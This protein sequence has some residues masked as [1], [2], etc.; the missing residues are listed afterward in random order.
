V[1]SEISGITPETRYTQRARIATTTLVQRWGGHDWDLGNQGTRLSTTHNPSTHYEVSITQDQ[2]MCVL[3]T[4][5]SFL[6][7]LMMS[8]SMLNMCS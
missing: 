2:S 7:I 6:D 3:D 4:Q 5:A 1:V 8:V